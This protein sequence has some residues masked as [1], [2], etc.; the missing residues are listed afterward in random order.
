M[1]NLIIKIC[2]W[3]IKQ[4]ADK[5]LHVLFGLIIAATAYLI[6]LPTAGRIMVAIWLPLIIDLIKELKIDASLDYMDV[7]YTLI[8]AAIGTTLAW[9]NT[10][11]A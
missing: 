11:C 3:L 1:K 7:L 8:G 5:W 10:I 2:A 4:G 9:L 6:P